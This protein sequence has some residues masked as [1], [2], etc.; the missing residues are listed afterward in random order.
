MK[1]L[2]ILLLCAAAL[3][4]PAAARTPPAM[5]PEPQRA[6]SIVVDKSE[7][8]MRLLR[9]GKLIRTYS[10]L[11]GDAPIGHK[12]QQ[13]DERTPEGAYRISGRNQNS[14]FHLS[15]RVSYPN[16]AD[17]KHASARG[18]DPGGDI[19]IHGGTPPGYR[20]DWTDGCIA[21]TDAQIEEV[22][23]LVPTGTPIRIDP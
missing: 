8:R 13:G 12:R 3:C 15:L 2:G 21:L 11:L 16:Q 14:R 23:S 10:I 9:D 22:W 1:A 20:R 19:M 18:V 4:A 5:A 17:R 7:R 6:D